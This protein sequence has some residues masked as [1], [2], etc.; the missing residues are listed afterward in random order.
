LYMCAPAVKAVGERDD[1]ELELEHR[2]RRNKYV[3]AVLEDEQGHDG[4]QHGQDGGD[5]QDRAPRAQAMRRSD[6]GHGGDGGRDEDQ[7]RQ[8]QRDRDVDVAAAAGARGGERPHH[9]VGADERDDHGGENPDH[10]A[11][12]TAL[13]VLY[14][15]SA[16]PT[17]LR[18][19]NS[20]AAKP[21]PI[22]HAICHKAAVMPTS[23]RSAVSPSRLYE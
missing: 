16:P 19:S 14:V 6:R 7:E 3:W 21:T 4:P 12:R 13:L 11:G 9:E 8:Q 2:S 23:V 10:F 1:R 18:L 20:I 5:D 15:A 22:H 17:M